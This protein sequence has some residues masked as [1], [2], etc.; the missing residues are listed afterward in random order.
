MSKIVPGGYY[1]RNGKPVDAKG[2][3]VKEIKDSP[4]KDDPLF[5]TEKPKAAPAAKS[6]K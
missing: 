5:V 1:I 3:P 6:S 2:N 4:Y